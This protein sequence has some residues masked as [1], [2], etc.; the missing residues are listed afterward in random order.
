MTV[1][2]AK[3]TIEDYHRMIASGI[4]ENRRVELLKGE[5]VEMA[6]EG[7]P[8]AYSSH[9]AGEYLSELLGGR[10]SVR[11]A[12]PVTLPN[13]SEPEPDLAIVQR[14]GREYRS[15]HPYPQN[16]FW[17]IE[18]SQSSL[19]KDLETK[20]SVYAEVGI[21][22]YWVVNLKESHLVV[23]RNPQNGK[24]LSKNFLANGTIQPL[25][26]PDVNIS[27]DSILNP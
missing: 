11:G 15:H 5:V 8:H 7:E 24:Y 17:L 6:P 10:A 12:K 21:L 20:S 27:V 26:F 16:I 4:L 9:E 2:L 23:F 25:A 19:A 14:L 13:D 1:I 22:E 18:Y 3:W